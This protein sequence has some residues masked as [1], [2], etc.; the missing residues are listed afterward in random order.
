MSRNRQWANQ[1]VGFNKD[2]KEERIRKLD[3]YN[4]PSIAVRALLEVEDIPKRVWEP[5]NV[6]LTNPPF[7]LAQEF[8]ETAMRLLPEGGRLYLLLR[9]QFLEGRKRRQM[10]IDHRLIRVHVFSYRLPRMHIFGHKGKKS[11]STLC[12]AWFVFERGYKGPTE[13]R[14][15]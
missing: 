2:M 10:F 5:A 7:R 11:T 15:I 6:I 8:V 13:L 3:G 4:S 14:W 1:T 12:F 9:L